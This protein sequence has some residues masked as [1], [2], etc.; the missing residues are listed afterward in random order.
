MIDHAALTVVPRDGAFG[1]GIRNVQLAPA[2]TATKQSRQKRAPALDSAA[3]HAALHVRVIGNQFAVRLVL[4]P[5][6]VARVVLDD[7]GLPFLALKGVARKHS[8]AS[9][10]NASNSPGLAKRVCAAISRIRQDVQ[11]G[12]IDGKL[13]YN[14]ATVRAVVHRG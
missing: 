14:V 2:V 10:H 11:K 3:D 4:V 7:Q 6:N 8:L 5:A 12:V 1:A 9:V 13:P